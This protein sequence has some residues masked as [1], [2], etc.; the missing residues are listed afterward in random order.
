LLPLLL[1]LLSPLLLLLLMPLPPPPLLLLL[2]YAQ[3]KMGWL[4][5]TNRQRSG[6][7]P[8]ERSLLCRLTVTATVTVT[9]NLINPPT[10]TLSTNLSLPTGR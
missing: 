8:S 1:L 9:S 10:P 4:P 2:C 6:V 5:P 3:G 7:M